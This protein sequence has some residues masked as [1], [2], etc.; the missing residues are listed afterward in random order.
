MFTRATRGPTQTHSRVPLAIPN[1]VDDSP[2][3]LIGNRCHSPGVAIPPYDTTT[4]A[5]ARRTLRSEP[6]AYRRAGQRHFH[7]ALPILPCFP[8]PPC[9]P[10]TTVARHITAG[11][12]S[13]ATKRRRR[14]RRTWRR[15]VSRCPLACSTPRR[16]APWHRHPSP[17]NTR[18]RS[19]ARPACNAFPLC[20]RYD[21]SPFRR[22]PAENEIQRYTIQKYTLRRPT[23]HEERDGL[24][25]VVLG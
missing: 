19:A 8:H 9:T 18:T 2:P 20:F 5:C 11:S 6:A 24:Q 22:Q 23:A 21:T 4:Q 14:R 7:P 25:F 3:A 12:E 1:C 13:P 10:P 15:A 16:S 17:K